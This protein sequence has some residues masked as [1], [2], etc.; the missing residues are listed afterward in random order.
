MTYTLY[1]L[2]Q[3]HWWGKRVRIYLLLWEA[4]EYGVCAGWSG[5]WLACVRMLERGGCV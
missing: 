2:Y 5:G 1:T 3:V 4:G